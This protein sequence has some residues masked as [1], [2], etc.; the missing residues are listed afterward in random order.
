M[1]GALAPLATAS[2]AGP[3]GASVP[4]DLAQSG[5]IAVSG[6]AS[7]S[8]DI[9]IGTS[10]NVAQSGSVALAGTA[11]I[12]GDIGI[13]TSF[14]VAPTAA[15]AISGTASISGDIEASAPI[16]LN[17]NQSSPIAMSGAASISGD[18]ATK[19]EF[20][21][22]P[23]LEISQMAGTLGVSGDI[24]I[25]TR[26]DIAASPIALSGTVS[27][28]GD[29][30][31]STTPARVSRR[32]AGRNYIIKGRRYFNITNEELAYLIARDL[33]DATRE[34]IKVTYK[35]KKARPI[36]KDAYTSMKE[37]VAALNRV[38]IPHEYD[39]SDDEEAI[40]ALL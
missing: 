8:G 16:R 22:E 28:S 25:V 7:V 35:N 34:D 19:V 37:A 9:G 4:F 40:L 30:A 26:F 13:G 11:T 3:V 24:Q 38:P 17:V 14:D 31:F 32:A 33:I 20:S 5:S 39:E 6:T 10:F 27:A 2:L 36:S 23:P 15:I 21:F 29:I 18:I 1:L 12:S